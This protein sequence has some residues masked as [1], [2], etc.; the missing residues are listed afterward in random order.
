MDSFYDNNVFR[1]R[2]IWYLGDTL[3]DPI[4]S[5]SSMDSFEDAMTEFIAI[6]S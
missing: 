5:L 1:Q 6:Y 3:H 2:L 4:W